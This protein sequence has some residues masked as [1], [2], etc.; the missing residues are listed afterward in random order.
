MDE[1]KPNS[2]DPQ[3]TI[4][5]S[6]NPDTN[7]NSKEHPTPNTTVAH[8]DT[9]PVPT[10][11]SALRKQILALAIPALGAL[12]AE[13]LFTFIDSAMV[14]HLGTAQLAGLGLASTV[15]N[16]IVGI[17]IF[18]AYS[19]TALAGQALG[20]GR[21]DRAIGSGIEAMWLAA[22]LGI[23]SAIA[24]TLWTEP[25][26]TFVGA[27]AKTMPHASAYL[28]WSA[29]GLVPMFVVYAATGTL[30]G[31][32][33]TK[34]PLIA[35]SAGAAFNVV[36]NWILMY[37]LSMGVGGSGAGTT[38]TQTLM[39]VGLGWVVVRAARTH[40]VRL[41]PSLGGL[42]QAALEG[43]PLLVR[44][45]ALRLALMGT[46]TVAAAVSV[47][48]LATHQVVWTVWS[49]AAYL[50]DAL[51]IAAQAMF[52]YAVGAGDVARMRQLL[53][54]LTRW[55]AVAGAGIGAVLVMMSPWLPRFFGSDAA[56]HDMGTILLMLAAVFMPVAG[57]V[58]LLDGVLIGAGRGRFL[59]VSGVINLA[60]YAPVLWGLRTWVDSSA[61][62]SNQLAP[63]ALL[64]LAFAGL[65]MGLR[66]AANAWATWRGR[67]PVIPRV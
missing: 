6:T 10:D 64:W 52:G 48:A 61:S 25:I 55:G 19:T 33:D 37:P 17:F 30:R 39:A 29:P 9:A 43:V 34:N 67:N 35:A 14:G 5:A 66:A 51:A 58:Y 63:M 12:I 28:K 4:E 21:P 26:L 15:L 8:A 65:Y 49:F 47:T 56:M 23:L 50:L 24:L 46:L 42:G 27:T 45:I 1:H 57:I 60:V 36:A 20:A 40:K 7:S 54:T 53:A 18:L 11:K 31:L 22:G 62:H 59:A 44:T 38:L 16:T 2:S 3:P 13:P 32:Q 41:A